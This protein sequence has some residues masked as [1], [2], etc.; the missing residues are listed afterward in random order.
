[1]NKSSLDLLTPN[2][3]TLALIDHEP[4]MFFGVQSTDRETIINNVEGLA[5]AAKIFKVPTILTTVAAKSFSGPLIPQLQAVFPDQKP[6]D[7]TTALLRNSHR[8]ESCLIAA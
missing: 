1:M 5:K 3:C 4:Q 2:N 7:R 6:I 8:T